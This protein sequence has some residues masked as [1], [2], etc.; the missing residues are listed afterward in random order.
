[1]SKKNMK[2]E[3]YVQYLVLNLKRSLSKL[4]FVLNMVTCVSL[5]LPS[6]ILNAHCG[7]D[8]FQNK[9]KLFKSHTIGNISQP[10]CST[11]GVFTSINR[12]LQAK[13]NSK[14]N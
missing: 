3:N 1:M 13:G 6:T 8:Y 14:A 7:G 9:T 4:S 11:Y 5:L 2:V 12:H 10:K